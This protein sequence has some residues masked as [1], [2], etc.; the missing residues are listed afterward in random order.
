LKNDEDVLQKTL[1]AQVGTSEAGLSRFLS[2]HRVPST[3]RPRPT[4]TTG[5]A[6][7]ESLSKRL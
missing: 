5:A 6:N 4:A 3:D 1:A 2:G 7:P